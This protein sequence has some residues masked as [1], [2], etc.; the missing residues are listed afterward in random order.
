MIHV[1]LHEYIHSLGFL[2]ER[3]TEQKTYDIS[4]KQFGKNHVITRLAFDMKN[5][6]QI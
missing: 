1:L 5:F 3:L 6:S 2:D 4:K